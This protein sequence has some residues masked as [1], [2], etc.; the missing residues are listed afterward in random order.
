MATQRLCKQCERNK[1]GAERAQKMHQV[2]ESRLTDGILNLGSLLCLGI[3][4]F[5]TKVRLLGVGVSHKLN[6]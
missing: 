2:R 3:L 1:S 4:D 6:V 5:W